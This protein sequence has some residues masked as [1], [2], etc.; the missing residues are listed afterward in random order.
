VIAL[1]A[2][3]ESA[4]RTASVFGWSALI[5]LMDLLAMWY[6]RRILMGFGMVVCNG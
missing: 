2:T 3:S 6:V 4:T 5:M 1:L